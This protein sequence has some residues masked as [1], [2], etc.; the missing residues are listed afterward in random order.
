LQLQLATPVAP[1]WQRAQKVA[2]GETSGTAGYLNRRAESAPRNF[3][4]RLQR[5]RKISSKPRRSTSGYLRCARCRGATDAYAAAAQLKQ[6][7]FPASLPGSLSVA[8]VQTQLRCR[9]LNGPVVP[10]EFRW[11]LFLSRLR[12]DASIRRR[13][14]VVR[15][16]LASFERRASRWSLF[17]AW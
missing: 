2:R 17:R 4:A 11:F 7:G 13:G 6:K 10:L 1:R 8:L 16:R 12:L 15:S 3:F 5:A 14:R 9:R